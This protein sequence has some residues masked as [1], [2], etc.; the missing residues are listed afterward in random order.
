MT[1]STMQGKKSKGSKLKKI[2]S[3]ALVAAFW[4]AVWEA[5]YYLV[6]QDILIASPQAVIARGAQL[7][8]TP[9]FWMTA[10][11]SLYRILIGYLVAV[12][13]G[14]VVAVVTSASKIVYSLLY[15][16]INILRVTPVASFIIL[17]LVWISAG[18]VP[19]LMAGIIVLPIVWAN[20]S[21]GIVETDPQLLEMAR[22]YRFGRLK[23]FRRIYVPSVAPYFTTACITGLGMAWKAGIAA[24]VL[25]VPKLAIGTNI[26]DA[27]RYIE[28]ADLFFWTLVVIILSMILEKA[29][30]LVV[31]KVMQRV[32]GGG[33]Q[34]GTKTRV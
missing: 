31:K 21:E 1:L 7:V 12:V 15:P 26:Y 27:K 16:I 22:M 14:V 30:R 20:V 5:L 9:E 13:A 24:E 11:L 28:T 29:V 3:A 17:A 34:S 8:V 33:A 18:A 23:T 32:I 10:G 4:I 2:G 6:N 25:S 19:S